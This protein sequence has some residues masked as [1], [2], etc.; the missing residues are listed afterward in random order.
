MYGIPPVHWSVGNVFSI[1]I[2]NANKIIEIKS[3]GD[4]SN[5]KSFTGTLDHVLAQDP[6]SVWDD[7]SF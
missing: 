5:E 4:L 1:T 6:S 2:A 7:L 3:L